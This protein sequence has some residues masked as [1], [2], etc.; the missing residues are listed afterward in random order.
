AGSS[1]DYGPRWARAL[2]RD[3]DPDFLRGIDATLRRAAGRR[4]GPLGDPAAEFAPLKAMG[5]WLGIATNDAEA[6]AR[7]QTDALGLSPH[8]DFLAGY[9]SGHGRKP[10]PGMVTAFAASVGCAPGEVLFV[11]DSAVD[12]ATARAAGA[13]AVGV[14]CGP[15]GREELASLADHLV[16]DVSAAVALAGRLRA[17][18]SPAA[19]ASVLA[20]T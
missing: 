1:V 15:A 4:L 3:A 20:R 11:G 9:D 7:A 10:A 12:M 16:A 19:S 17:G 18:A 14:L 6:N 2:G 5:F 8:L 13:V